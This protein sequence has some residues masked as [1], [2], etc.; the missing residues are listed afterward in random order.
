MDIIDILFF[1][2]RKR[3]LDVFFVFQK[4]LTKGLPQGIPTHMIMSAN[5][6]HFS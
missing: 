6:K 1:A 5:Q 4:N 2:E 3:K